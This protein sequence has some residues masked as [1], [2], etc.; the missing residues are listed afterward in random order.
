VISALPVLAGVGLESG[1]RVGLDRVQET[2]W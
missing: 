1:I 2:F